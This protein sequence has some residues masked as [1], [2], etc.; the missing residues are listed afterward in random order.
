VGRLDASPNVRETQ[1]RPTLNGF[2]YLF[3][4]GV[5]VPNAEFLIPC[6]KERKDGHSEPRRVRRCAVGEGCIFLGK[7]SL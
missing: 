5:Q 7:E 6:R 4:K 1:S 2:A 3:D